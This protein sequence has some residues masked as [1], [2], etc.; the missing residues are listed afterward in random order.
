M[1][2][3]THLIK[4]P[5]CGKMLRADSLGSDLIDRLPKPPVDKDGQEISSH[6]VGNCP[7]CS[8]PIEIINGQIVETAFP[9]FGD[10]Y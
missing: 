6:Y 4:C 7:R 9:A 2:T 1:G 10:V 8:E 5:G 3:V